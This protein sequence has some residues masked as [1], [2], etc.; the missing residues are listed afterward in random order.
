MSAFFP[1]NLLEQVHG[2]VLF[3]EMKVSIAIFEFQ[4]PVI[5]IVL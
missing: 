4:Q 2:S 3:L 1:S 5:M